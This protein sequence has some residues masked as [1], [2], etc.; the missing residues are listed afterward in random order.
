MAVGIGL[1]LNELKTEKPVR[2]HQDCSDTIRACP[3]LTWRV[4]KKGTRNDQDQKLEIE[5]RGRL[6]YVVR[7]SEVSCLDDEKTGNLINRI[8]K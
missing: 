2:S 4:E 1:K 5:G 3:P 6:N 7:V 8:Q